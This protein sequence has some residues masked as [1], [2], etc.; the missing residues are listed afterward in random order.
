MASSSAVLRGEAETVHR[1]G[2]GGDNID[3]EAG[4]VGGGGAQVGDR[5]HGDVVAGGAGFGRVGDGRWQAGA[6]AGVG[7]A[8]DGGREGVHGWGGPL[9]GKEGEVGIRQNNFNS[10]LY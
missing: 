9:V 2:V 5:H 7:F 1:V 10:Y 8:G 4:L 3:G 6:E